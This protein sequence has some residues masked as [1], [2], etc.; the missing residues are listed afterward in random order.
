MDTKPE[1]NPVGFTDL[2]GAHGVS[3]SDLRIQLLGAI[4]EA[5]AALSLAKG[6]LDDSGL[7]QVLKSCQ[8]DLSF[9]MSFTARIGTEK[10]LPEDPGF[11]VHELVELERVLEEMYSQVAMPDKFIFPGESQVTGALDLARTIVRRSERTLNAGFDSLG[12]KVP[13]ARQYINRLS[14][15]CYLLILRFSE[16]PEE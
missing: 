8:Q 14:S 9:L 1:K 12:V 6:F 2:I 16:H 15:L 13:N 11:F 5:S 4:D 7:I 3:K 10:M